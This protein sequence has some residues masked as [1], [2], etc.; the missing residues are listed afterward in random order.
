M[1]KIENLHKTFNPGT[2]H[3]VHALVG[4]N[5]E[6]EEGSFVALLGT[7]G[8]GKSTLLNAIAGSFFPDTGS[9]LLDGKNISNY[10]EHKRARFIGRVFQNPFTG[11]AP[12]MTIAENLALASKR[13]MKRGI[14][15][16]LQS[17]RME[18][19]RKRRV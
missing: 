14:A 16:A 15:M 6:I 1:L 3:E 12:D 18:N 2:V 19:F 17:K 9:I 10:P 8:S 13:G 11:T 5:C 4:I 7:N